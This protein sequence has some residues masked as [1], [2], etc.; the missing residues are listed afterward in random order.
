MKNRLQ[1]I[2]D[3]IGNILLY[4]DENAKQ[5]IDLLK[6]SISLIEVIDA[7]PNSMLETWKNIALDEIANELANRINDHFFT[8]DLERKKSEFKFS[9][10]VVS[11]SITNILMNY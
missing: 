8:A 9:K 3:I 10:S 2:H 1:E 6:E 4:S 11:M 7:K 5:Y